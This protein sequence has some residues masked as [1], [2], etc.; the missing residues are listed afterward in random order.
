MVFAADAG[1]VSGTFLVMAP[2]GCD[3]GDATAT[4]LDD[5]RWLVVARYDPAESVRVLVP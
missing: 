2:A 1:V 5:G 3:P 4:C